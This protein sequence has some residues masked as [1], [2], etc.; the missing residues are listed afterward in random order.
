M[1]SESTCLSWR[2][3]RIKRKWQ[4]YVRVWHDEHVRNVKPTAASGDKL[5]LLDEIDGSGKCRC[6]HRLLQ[7]VIDSEMSSHMVYADRRDVFSRLAASGRCARVRKQVSNLFSLRAKQELCRGT[8]TRYLNKALHKHARERK[9]LGMQDAWCRTKRSVCA[10]VRDSLRGE[11]LSDV[12]R[13][14]SVREK[15]KWKQTRTLCRNH[16]LRNTLFRFKKNLIDKNL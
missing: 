2:H 15:A 7:E 16:I 5:H 3:R 4:I 8:L 14:K 13:V 12:S 9:L 1:F 10:P 11:I 6:C